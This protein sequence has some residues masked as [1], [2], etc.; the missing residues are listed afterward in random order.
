MKSKVVIFVL[1]ALFSTQSMLATVG[2]N[3]V[4]VHPCTESESEK[5]D[6]TS[7]KIKPIVVGARVVQSQSPTNVNQPRGETRD[8]RNLALERIDRYYE[9]PCGAANSADVWLRRSQSPGL[10]SQ[11]PVI[12]P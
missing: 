6:H 11:T 12:F 10:R 2:D 4:L 8:Q 7:A 5:D 9:S 1:I 3:D